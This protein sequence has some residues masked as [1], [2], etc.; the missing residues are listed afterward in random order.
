MDQP[1][2]RTSM[3]IGAALFAVDSQRK[4]EAQHLKRQRRH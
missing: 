2:D 1:L 3:L 4:T